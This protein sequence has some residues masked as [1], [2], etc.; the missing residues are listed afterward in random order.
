LFS[1]LNMGKGLFRSYDLLY[2]SA[3]LSNL[4]RLNSM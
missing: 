1:R 2:D 3:V 4:F